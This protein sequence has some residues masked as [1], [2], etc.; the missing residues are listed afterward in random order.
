[1]RKDL[2]IMSTKTLAGWLRIGWCKNTNLRFW[3]STLID[4][5][6]WNLW[7][8]QGKF[9]LCLCSII[10]CSWK[11]LTITMQGVISS[12]K[13]PTWRHY[14]GLRCSLNS[15]HHD[16]NVVGTGVVCANGGSETWRRSGCKVVPLLPC[17]AQKQTYLDNL[18]SK[19]WIPLFGMPNFCLIFTLE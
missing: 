4:V 11:R 9:S 10:A 18:A 19:R 16:Y 3:F 13:G 5:F 15:R 7:G 6:C 14:L 1:M 8:K 2:F 17:A 12:K